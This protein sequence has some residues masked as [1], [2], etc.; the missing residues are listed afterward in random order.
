MRKFAVAAISFILMSFCIAASAQELACPNV[1]EVHQVQFDATSQKLS[2]ERFIALPERI[3]TFNNIPWLV[4][5][6]GLQTGSVE[7]A[8][9]QLLQVDTRLSAQ[10][11]QE[12]LM[13]VPILACQYRASKLASVRIV[14]IPFYNTIDI[15]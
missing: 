2:G 7:T 8:N 4:I 1:A 6:T 10:V 9:Q 13:T 14:A 3:Y 12:Y 11:Q 15:I 5:L